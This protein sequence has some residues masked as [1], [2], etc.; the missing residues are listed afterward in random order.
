M[1]GMV[2]A[3]ILAVFFIPIFYVVF[4]R[5]DERLHKQPPPT[6]EAVLATP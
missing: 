1:G 5:L 6:A 3:T 4:Q 2:A